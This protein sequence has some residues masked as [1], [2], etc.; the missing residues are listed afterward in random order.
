V[1]ERPST[2]A[3]AVQQ[4]ADAS[5]HK[6]AIRLD[7]AECTYQQLIANAEARAQQLLGLGLSRGDRFGILLPN[8]LE[9][10]ELLLAASMTGLVAVP[11]N[12]RFKSFELHHIVSH[13]GMK[14]IVMVGQIQ[15][16]VDYTDTLTSAL[17]SLV[18]AKD[19]RA[20]CPAEAPELRSIVLLSGD[21]GSIPT[22]APDDLQASPKIVPRPGD[23][24]APLLIMYTSGTTANPK[25]CVISQGA[26]LS[27]I[28]GVIDR[29]AL[30]PADIWWCPLPMFHVG[31]ILFPMLLLVVGGT[32]L[33]TAYFEPSSAI[34]MIVSAQPTVLYPLFPTITLQLMDSPRIAEIALDK[35][36]YIVNV[37]PAD[38]Q[39]RIQRA[40]DPAVLLGAFGMTETTGIVAYGSATDDEVQRLTT[41]GAALAHWEVTIVDPD[42]KAALPR[43]AKGEISVRGAG[44][45]DAYLDDDDATRSQFTA[46]GFFLTGDSGMLDSDGMLHFFGRLKD[47]LKVGGENVSALEVESFLATHSSI[48]LAQVVGV[49]DDRYGEVIAAFIEMHD[50]QSLT[51]EEVISFCTGSI[52]RFKIPRYVRFVEAWPMSATKIQKFRLKTALE[53]EMAT[54]AIH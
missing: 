42:T 26:L 19:A 27:N 29:L 25:G 53:A 13:S 31:G 40:F 33:T 45:F 21:L 15:D 7:A 16:V 44:L 52:A 39:R 20:L 24:N 38:L 8:C 22:L 51:E 47:Q 49:A 32:Y 41:C 1:F 43:D 35:V 3:Q 37:A 23:R 54:T 46:D 48:K 10:I 11:I 9:T 36:R 2:L 18:D 17:P 34:D 30:T 50:G 12:T 4:S 14:T 5:P 28:D 6:I